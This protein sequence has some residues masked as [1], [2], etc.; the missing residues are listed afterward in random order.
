[1]TIE[2]H[3]RELSTLSIHR[4][5]DCLLK[6]HP[7]NITNMLSMKYSSILMISVDF[8]NFYI[9]KLVKTTSSTLFYCLNSC[10]ERLE[11]K[12]R[13]IRIQRHRQHWGQSEYRDTGNIGHNQ[14]TETQATLGTIRIQR[15]RQHCAQSEYRDTGNIEDNQNTET[16]A[17]LGTIRIQRHRQHWGQSEYGDTGKIE[18]NQNTETQAP[19]RAIRIQKHG[20]HWR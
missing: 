4:N 19:L 14:N 16:Q 5:G 1:M 8:Y 7:T 3:R 9:I 15:H 6:K 2:A 17:T 11:K 13:A 18:G 20:Q 10:K 12:W